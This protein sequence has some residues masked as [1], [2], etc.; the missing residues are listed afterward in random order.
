MGTVDESTS[1]RVKENVLDQDIGPRLPRDT[2]LTS[3]FLIV[4]GEPYRSRVEAE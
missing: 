2:K 4:S 3:E 1:K